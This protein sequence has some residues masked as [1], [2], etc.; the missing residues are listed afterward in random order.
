MRKFGNIRSNTI[1]LNG[2]SHYDVPKVEHMP[3]WAMHTTH[4]RM[5]A[6]RDIAERTGRDPRL[7]TL[8]V[9]IF[10]KNGIQPRD[11]KGQCQALLNW[12]QKNIYYVNEPQERLQCPIYTLK[13]GYGD[14]DD[15]VLLLCS[16]AESVKIEWKFVLSGKNK[17]GKIVRWIEGDKIPNPEPKWVHIYCVLGYPPFNPTQWVFAEPT[18]RNVPLGWDI[19]SAGGNVLP[20]FAGIDQM[21]S[22]MIA[23]IGENKEKLSQIIKGKLHYTELIPIIIVG[24]LTSVL[25]SEFTHYIVKPTIEHIKKGMGVKKRKNP[26]RK[27][28]TKRKR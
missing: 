25:I 6:L 17:N 2:A 10:K 27:K 7:A 23:M 22:P 16:L 11:Y 28:T 3:L 24:S 4:D 26:K 21:G 14:C 1:S 12:V 5:A 13:V 8:A 18:L 9:N 19:V 20:E 15:M